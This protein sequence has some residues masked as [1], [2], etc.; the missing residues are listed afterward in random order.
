[1]NNKFEKIDE[2]LNVESSIVDASNDSASIKKA[3]SR[4]WWYWKRLWVY[5]GKFVFFNWKRSRR[6]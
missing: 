4:E 1:M 3:P 2:A 6:Q 5:K